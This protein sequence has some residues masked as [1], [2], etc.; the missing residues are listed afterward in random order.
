MRAFLRKLKC[1]F[2]YHE[3][4]EVKERATS[5]EGA[6]AGFPWDSWNTL[7][8]CIHCDYE[9]YQNAEGY[10]AMMRQRRK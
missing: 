10:R 3:Y 8:W 7:R 9:I 5:M 4:D 2:G 6:N 1:F